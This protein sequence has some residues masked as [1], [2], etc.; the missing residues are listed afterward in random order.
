MNSRRYLSA[1]SLMVGFH[2]PQKKILFENL[3]LELCAG[4]VVCFMGPNG[5]GKST[6]IRTLA[7]LQAPLSGEV[8]LLES[9]E[10]KSITKLLSVVLTTKS[11]L[12]PMTVYE[13][14]SFG[15]YPYLR[16]NISLTDEDHAI[17]KRS[18]ESIGI[19][20]LADMNVL[21]LSDG[22]LQMVMIARALCQDTSII[23]LD[24]PTAHLDL[25]NRLEIMKHL[26][27]IACEMNK[28]ILV[29]THELDLALQIADHVWLATRD[30]SI[31][32]GAP[33]DLV[34]DGSFDEIFQFKGFDL[35]TGKVVHEV[36]EP[37]SIDLTGEGHGLLWTKNA[38]ERSGF[39]VKVVD[40]NSKPE[41]A[42]HVVI[43]AEETKPRWILKTINQQFVSLTIAK[44]IERLQSNDCKIPE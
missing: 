34:L 33:E 32:R 1:S 37:M 38:L 7:S 6:L 9:T 26:K 10:G 30:K 27:R 20:K 29:S 28:A 25:N 2:Q 35:R 14:V 5:I 16:W 21:E 40:R 17:V 19:E 8:K 15:R 42:F 3:E 39:Q 44:L 23:L 18:L 31:L 41:S 4:Q 11:P 36:S 22:Q 13:M 12:P 43:E 24:E